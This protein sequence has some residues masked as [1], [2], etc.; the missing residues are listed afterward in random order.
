MK[1]K[2]I[3]GIM[4]GTSLDGID[5][6]LCNFD[7]KNGIWS[8]KIIKTKTVSYS[9]VWHK[10]LS[11]AQNLSGSDFVKLHNEYGNYIGK[12][13]KKFLKNT[14]SA[15]FVASHGHT[16][17]H[18]PEK[19]LCFQIGNGAFI[20]AK[21]QIPVVSDFRSLDIALGGQG[22]PLV[23]VGDK[24]LFA[25]Y[26][27]CINLGGFANISYDNNKKIR[28]AFDLCPVNIIV[29]KLSEK[30]RKKYDKNG[31]IGKKGIL[32]KKLFS[33]LN[34]LDYYFGKK[35]KSLGREFV[36]EKFIPVLNKYNISTE[37]KIR[38]IYEHVAYQIYRA[39]KFSKNKKILL[40]GGGAHNNFLVSKIKKL[41]KNKIII[42]E[43]EIIDFKE[44]IIFAFLG[45]LRINNQNNCL[46]SVTG[47][48]SDNCGGIINYISSNFQ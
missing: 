18:K 8:F 28:T 32:N 5:F 41:N 3:L 12:L 9:S 45:L 34:N 25:K 20:S 47:S 24:L 46:S 14:Q 26:D 19:K 27:F 36:E 21:L 31:K 16:I 30:R 15:D 48:I 6:A 23:P 11:D 13:A 7:K 38:T 39:T 43:K 33:E 22:A 44:A 29:N 1:N 40:T 10:K 4:S 35:N 37:N 2:N 17:F 42:P